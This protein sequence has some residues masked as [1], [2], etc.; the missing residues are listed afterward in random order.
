MSWS[1][2]NNNGI[3]SLQEQTTLQS[4]NYN[5]VFKNFFIGFWH[6]SRPARNRDILIKRWAPDMLHPKQWQTHKPAGKK[7]KLKTTAYNNEGDI[8][9]VVGMS[10]ERMERNT[11]KSSVYKEGFISTP[12]LCMP[13]MLGLF[14]YNWEAITHDKCSFSVVVVNENCFS[15]SLLCQWATEDT[16]LWKKK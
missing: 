13:E 16:E 10:K 2:K 4:I 5:I 12:F 8:S 14:K 15:E 1:E 7:A 3:L 11:N 9:R 6:F